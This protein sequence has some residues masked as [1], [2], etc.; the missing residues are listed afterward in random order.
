[1]YKVSIYMP[2]GVTVHDTLMVPLVASVQKTWRRSREEKWSPKRTICEVCDRLEIAHGT[3][4]ASLLTSVQAFSQA[5][6]FESHILGR[7]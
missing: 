3:A 7:Q 4:A 2:L 1:M 6:P 5:F